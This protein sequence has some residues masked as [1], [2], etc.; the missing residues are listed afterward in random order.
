MARLKDREKQIPNGLTFYE[1]ALK[2]RPAPYSSMDT[3]VRGLIQARRAN[4]YLVQRNGWS[5]DYATVANEVDRYN[6]AICKAHRW[7]QFID[8]ENYSP[9]K[10]L[11]RPGP[12]TT[13]VRRSVGN[14]AV[15]ANILTEWLG[16]GG[17]AVEQELA[18]SR[19]HVCA[20]CPQNKRDADW[21]SWF[22]IPAANTIRKML[23]LRA[24]MKLSTP[25]D[26]M[27]NVCDACGCPLKLKVHT[28]LK[29]ITANMPPYQKE[30]LDPRC[31]VLSE[32]K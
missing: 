8:E 26:E 11:P 9:P 22:T 3:I 2:W 20:T 7:T 6:A 32:A 15:G 23:E 24:R 31:W 21:T 13:L 30:S 29:H 17:K 12:T 4:P 28:P 18:D 1:P 14:A 25:E 27:L 16:A 19:A 5:V 10:G